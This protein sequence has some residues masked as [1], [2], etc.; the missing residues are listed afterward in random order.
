MTTDEIERLRADIRQLTIGIDGTLVTEFENH[1]GEMIKV[2][3]ASEHELLAFFWGTVPALLLK[4]GL[5]KSEFE[6]EISQKE[7]DFYEKHISATFK[8]KS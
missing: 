5:I 2:E 8:S 4:T 1:N 3:D 6:P 7:K